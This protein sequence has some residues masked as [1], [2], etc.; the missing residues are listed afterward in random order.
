[1]MGGRYCFDI[2]TNGL[3]DKLTTVHCIVAIDLDTGEV[4]QFHGDTLHDGVALVNDASYLVGHN[5][6]DFDIPALQKVYPWCN[7]TG[8]IEDSLVMSRLIFT[9]LK[10]L[11]FKKL[12]KN[13]EY[14]PTK[15]LVGSHGLEA[16]GH[17]LS[18]HKGDYSAEMKEQGLD[19]WAEFNDA[20]L[21]YCV[22]DVKLNVH[23]LHTL[24]RREFDATSIRLEH[25]VFNLCRQQTQFGCSFNR[26]K[27]EE[28]YSK[29]AV[30]KAKIERELKEV[31]PP[32]FTDKGK[33]VPKRNNKTAGYLQDCP[34]TK[35][36][37]VEF[38]PASRDHIADRLQQLRGWKPK[39]Y[40][41]NGKPKVDENVLKN[42]PWPE[43]KL[44]TE[45]LL[46][47]KRLGQL[48][49]GREAWLKLEKEGR[50]HGRVN[51]N[52]AVTGRCTHSRPNL[53]QVPSV[54]A[55][56]GADCRSLF[57]ATPGWKFV[58]ADASGLELRCL[59]HYLARWDGGAYGQEILSGD[60]H[61]ANQTAAGLPTRDQAK[62]FIYALL[63]GAGDA[64]IGHVIGKGA[65]AGRKLRQ[66]FMESLPAFDRLIST[67]SAKAD[68]DGFVRGLE[69]R[70]LFI[71]SSHAALNT[72]LQ[73]AGAVIM[74]QA[75]V[76]FHALCSDH[77]LTH[78][79]HYRQ[80]LFV[81]DEFQCEAL[82]EHV[83]R[84]GEFMVQG[85]KDVTQDFSLRCPLD[86]EYKVGD[87]WAETH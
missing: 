11:D 10:D 75:M 12:A 25:A 74:K 9:D 45:Y 67:V 32:W 47:L 76:N 38:N 55:P 14:F 57:Q 49:D 34:L 58:G 1:M 65:G 46:I 37:M 31:F 3:L 18:F 73:G 59:A 63:Y 2:E 82:P 40:T 79:Q 4:Y 39:E 69:G 62:T 28:L 30:R 81:H 64:K 19:P 20:M 85:I 33:F 5:I 23:L 26:S 48:G 43:T 68:R 84:V 29:L 24:A 66:S 44:L 17:R 60:I 53:A 83:D 42:L 8:Y 80:V 78:G 54:R 52:G 15:R 86:G 41:D 50:I 77:G 70:K 51:T 35:V 87:N 27:A 71:R 16:W 72:L 6:I 22:N 7:P 61:T 36:E 21:D 13:P 56:Y